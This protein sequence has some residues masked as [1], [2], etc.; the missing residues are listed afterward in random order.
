[1]NLDQELG[2]SLGAGG[3]GDGRSRVYNFSGESTS[4]RMLLFLS[5]KLFRSF[6]FE[7]RFW[8]LWVRL[9]SIGRDTTPQRHARRRS[10]L[11]AYNSD[12][13]CGSPQFSS[14]PGSSPQ[15]SSSPQP[16]R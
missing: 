3:V 13:P 1:M 10:T 14:S 12:R 4:L 16:I 2:V 8:K 5:F 6:R 9:I 7:N 11:G 15:F